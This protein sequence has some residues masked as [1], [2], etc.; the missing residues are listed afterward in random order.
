M[1]Q[2]FVGIQYVPSPLDYLIFEDL[3]LLL[4]FLDSGP[5]L[6]LLLSKLGILVDFMLELLIEVVME[7]SEIIL[8]Q[9]KLGSELILNRILH[10]VAM[11]VLIDLTWH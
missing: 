7:N 3:E 10:L 5:N 6:R 11:G 8:S 9:V 4:Q 2:K 1:F